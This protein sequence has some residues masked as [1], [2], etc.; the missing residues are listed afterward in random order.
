MVL[1]LKWSHFRSPQYSNGKCV[2]LGKVW[3]SSQDLNNTLNHLNTG[4]VYVLFFLFLVYCLNFEHWLEIQTCVSGLQ[5]VQV[6]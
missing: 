1:D 6:V 3:C 2:W 4:L 5:I